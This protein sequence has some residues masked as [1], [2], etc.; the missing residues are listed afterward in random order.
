MFAIVQNGVAHQ[1]IIDEFV[2]ANWKLGTFHPLYIGPV[3]G[4]VA[5]YGFFEE[6]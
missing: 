3:E 5:E 1:V 4:L 2:F 6:L